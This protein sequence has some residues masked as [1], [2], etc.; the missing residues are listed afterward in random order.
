MANTASPITQAEVTAVVCKLHRG[1][2][3]GVDEIYLVYLRSLDVVGLSW[4]TCLYNIAGRLGT[5]PLNWATGVVVLIFKKGDR[6]VCSNY[7]GITLFSLPWKAY[8]RVL[9]RR[10]WLIVEPRIQREQRCFRPG[11]GTLDQLYTLSRVLEG[12]WEYAQPVQVFCGLGEGVRL[13]PL[14]H[15]VEGARGVKGKRRSVEGCL[16][17]LWTE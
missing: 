14:W 10:I 16:V 7:R 5:V 4:L 1:K 6:R 8:A 9:E 2:A 12:S 15:S 17:P 11:R 3:A 13:C